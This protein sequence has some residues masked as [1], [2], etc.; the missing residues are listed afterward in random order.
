MSTKTNVVPFVPFLLACLTG[1]LIII[2]FPKASLWF[3][4]WIAFIPLLYAVKNTDLK[5]SFLI[6][7]VSGFAASVGIFYWIVVAVV[8]DG[9]SIVLGILCL[10]ALSAYMALYYGVFA[11][12]FSWGVRQN[13]SLC[14]SVYGASLWV[15]LEYVRMY[16]FT[17]FPWLLLGYSQWQKLPL[18]QIA[19][20]GGVYAVSFL[21]IW[22]NIVIFLLL[23]EKNYMK[24]RCIINTAVFVL[25]ISF[26]LL[27]GKISITRNMIGSSKNFLSF[28]LLQGNIDQYR[29]WD[30]AYENDIAGSYA[31]LTGKA[32]LHSPDLII[33]PETAFPGFFEEID[34][35][36]W[37]DNLVKSSKTSHLVSAASEMDGKFYNSSFLL[38]SEAK[39]AGRYDKKHLVLFGEKVPFQKLL[40][41]F[42][43][44]LNK[45]GGFT[46]GQGNS[47]VAFK[48]NVGSN[49]DTVTLYLGISICFEAIFPALIRQS[50][51]DGAQVLIN[52]TNDAW[53][54]KTAAAYQHLIMNVFRAVEN[55][56]FL[57]RSANTGITAVIGPT[58][59]IIAQTE[60]FET[61]LLN[62]VCSMDSSQTFY[63]RWG[64][65]FVYGCLIFLSVPVLVRIYKN[66]KI[67]D[68]I[69]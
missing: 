8:S 61:T 31:G 25:C 15:V 4:A 19:S 9:N 6:G 22:G 67:F 45:L 68:N 13:S 1:I 48:K 3:C 47:V 65:L 43:S 41:R 53:Y 60:L 57:L 39:L 62:G 32:A 51:R 20:V 33:W 52:V 14:L 69:Q 46:E 66:K 35:R 29:K 17:G 40:G 44:V 36:N 21:I 55:N 59:A 28:S 49:T 2:S 16:L 26:T 64:D 38:T 50:V 27:L 7:C 23:Q 54:L 37:L 30:N 11:L 24:L 42:I 58:G 63:T 18:I 10:C 12:T 5:Q 56:R 34:K